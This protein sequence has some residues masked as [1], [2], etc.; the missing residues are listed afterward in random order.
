MKTLLV[1]FTRLHFNVHFAEPNK[2]R[3]LLKRE[4]EGVLQGQFSQSQTFLYSDIVFKA[5]KNSLLLIQHKLE[6][7][8]T[9]TFLLLTSINLERTESC[10][11]KIKA[12]HILDRFAK[13][14]SLIP[15]NLLCFLM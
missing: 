12:I 15:S 14:L 9:K 5:V 2:K 7:E 13:D 8:E 4:G 3:V 11:Q 10:Q 1:Q 6:F